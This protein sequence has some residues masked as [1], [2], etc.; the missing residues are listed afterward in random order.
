MLESVR[1]DD[2]VQIMA[3]R[4]SAKAAPENTLAAFRQA[5][6]DKADWIELDVQETADGQVV[7]FHDSDFM[8]LSRVNL[9]IWDATMDK[10]KDIDIGSWFAPQFKRRTCPHAGRCP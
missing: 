4:G 8:K 2:R 10:L 5:I 6:T 3:H 7:V 9:K 1:L